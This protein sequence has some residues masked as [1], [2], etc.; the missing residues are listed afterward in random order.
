MTKPAMFEATVHGF[1]TIP[2]RGVVSITV[3]APLEKH[4]EIARIAEHGAWLVLARLDPEK[5]NNGKE[6]EAIEERGKQHPGPKPVL[7]QPHPSVDHDKPREGG[8]K[9]RFEDLLCSQ[10][11]GILCNEPAFYRYLEET[12]WWGDPVANAGE[13]ADA[14]RSI[15]AVSSRS[16]IDEHVQSQGTWREIVS[17]YRAWKLAPSVIG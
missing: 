1:R 7:A 11:A 10:Q 5:V 14:I 8:A 9:R 2:S 13:A 3:E 4:A 12:T 17:D 6:G 15:C 16:E